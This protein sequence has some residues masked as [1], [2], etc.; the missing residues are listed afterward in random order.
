MVFLYNAV[1]SMEMPGVLKKCSR[2]LYNAMDSVKMP[3]I[4][5]TW[6]VFIKRN[7]FYENPVVFRNAM[8]IM[9]MPCILWKC[10]GFLYNAMDSVEMP[11]VL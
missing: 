3:W 4:L 9:K 2:F 10:F 6:C 1:D 7:G 8:D 11:W 5:W